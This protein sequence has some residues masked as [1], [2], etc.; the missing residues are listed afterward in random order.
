MFEQKADLTNVVD[1]ATRDYENY[2][3]ECHREEI[4]PIESVEDFIAD[5]VLSAGYRKQIE[6]EWLAYPSD[7]Y[8]KCSVC[9]KEYLRSKMPHTVGYCPNPNCGAKMKGGEA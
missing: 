8:M 3:D 2:L 9:K 6:G 5:A 7:A 1:Y 4:P